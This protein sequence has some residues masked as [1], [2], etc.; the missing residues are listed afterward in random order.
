[1]AKFNTDPDSLSDIQRQIIEGALICGFGKERRRVESIKLKPRLFTLENARFAHKVAAI[2][3][4]RNQ[5]EVLL[6]YL[7]QEQIE[8]YKEKLNDSLPV[9]P[10]I[11]DTKKY[12]IGGSD[13]R[14]SS[15]YE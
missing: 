8:I 15:F 4:V 1:M 12:F 3:S 5:C 7:V 13:V 9:M 10:R 2:D 14:V 6:K 11:H